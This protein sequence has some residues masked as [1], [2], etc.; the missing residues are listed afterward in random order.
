MKKQKEEFEI[1][2]EMLLDRINEYDEN[3]F[4]KRAKD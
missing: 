1:L 2:G 4:G 3:S